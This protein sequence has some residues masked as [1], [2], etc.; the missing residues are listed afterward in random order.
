MDEKYVWLMYPPDAASPPVVWATKKDAVEAVFRNI[1]ETHG[2]HDAFWEAFL[3]YLISSHPKLAEGYYRNQ[4]DWT[5][6]LKKALVAYNNEHRDPKWVLERH[7]VMTIQKE[8]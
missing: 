6:E 4:D 5:P 8:E 7:R 1:S 2:D 3:E